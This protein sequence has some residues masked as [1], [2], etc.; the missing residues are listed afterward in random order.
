MD[1]L[2][3]SLILEMAKGYCYLIEKELTTWEDCDLEELLT[4]LSAL[5]ME[6]LRFPTV[7]SESETI[8]RVEIKLPNISFGEKDSYQKVYDPYTNDSLVEGSLSDDILDIYKDVK[9][10]LMLYEKGEELEALWQLKFSFHSHWITHALDAMKTI[11]S[12]LREHYL[13]L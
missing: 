7:D 11:Q 9:E 5:Y 2:Q 12:L 4:R 10:G 6:A 13:T 1:Y 3:K 8:L